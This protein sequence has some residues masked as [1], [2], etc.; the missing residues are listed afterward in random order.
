MYT[1]IPAKKN[2]QKEKK[3]ESEHSG[4]FSDGPT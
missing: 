2:Q 3:N 1:Y 4:E